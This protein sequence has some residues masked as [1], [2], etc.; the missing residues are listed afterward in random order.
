MTLL[1]VVSCPFRVRSRE[2]RPHDE[3]A[4]TTDNR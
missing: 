3:K 2:Y 1:S 4:Q